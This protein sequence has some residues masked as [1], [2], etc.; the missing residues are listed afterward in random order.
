MKFIIKLLLPSLFSVILLSCIDTGAV[1]I[2]P[3]PTKPSWMLNWFNHPICSPPCW[4]NII[5]G[6]TTFDEANKILRSN[7]EITVTYTSVKG[8]F[9]NDKEIQWEFVGTSDDGSIV[10]DEEGNIIT[11]IALNF[12]SSIELQ[13]MLSKFGEPSHVDVFDCRSEVQQSLCSANI[14][15]PDHG[16]A[17]EIYNRQDHKDEWKI[18]ITPELKIS[19]VWFFPAGLE[20]YK[21]IFNN[22]DYI[23]RLSSWSGYKVYP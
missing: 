15:Y 9:G 2:R 20:G 21:Y 23:N 13:E 19:R 14:I 6:I 16:M 10:T 3:T 17:I 18:N 5:P 22:T 12:A 8:V 4:S 11:R 1:F 7:P